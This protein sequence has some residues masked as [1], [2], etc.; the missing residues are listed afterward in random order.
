MI[1]GGVCLDSPS[2]GFFVKGRENEKFR[3]VTSCIMADA[4]DGPVDDTVVDGL[5]GAVRDFIGGVIGSTIGDAVDC[6]RGAVGDAI[7]DTIYGHCAAVGDSFR[8]VLERG[9]SGGAVMSQ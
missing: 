1:P 7:G 6:D 8:D 5:S 2:R 9:R 4:I 3:V